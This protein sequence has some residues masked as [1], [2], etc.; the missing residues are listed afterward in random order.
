MPI[1]FAPK[2]FSE[3]RKLPVLGEQGQSGPAK[4]VPT[5]RR[6]YWTDPTPHPWAAGSRVAYPASK[7]SSNFTCGTVRRIS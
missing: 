6:Q 1:V 3:R 5:L 7:K 2:L 4:S